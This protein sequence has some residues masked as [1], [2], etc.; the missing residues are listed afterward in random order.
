MI[1]F[2]Y[3]LTIFQL[4]VNFRIITGNLLRFVFAGLKTKVFYEDLHET[5]FKKLFP[6]IFLRSLKDLL[7]FVLI[8]SLKKINWSKTVRRSFSVWYV[9]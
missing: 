9:K 2:V 5:S 7:V 4:V 8:F 3:V 1:N 6:N